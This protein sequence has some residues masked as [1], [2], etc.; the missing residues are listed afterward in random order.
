MTRDEIR[1]E[2]RTGRYP[3]FADLEHVGVLVG[4]RNYLVDLWLSEETW[5]NAPVEVVG[6]ATNRQVALVLTWA[7]E[8]IAPGRGVAGYGPAVEIEIEIRADSVELNAAKLEEALADEIPG[9][10]FGQPEG[11]APY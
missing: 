2:L 3:D 1:A 10:G 6:E 8:Q 11:E 5:G 7:I 4:V 9:F